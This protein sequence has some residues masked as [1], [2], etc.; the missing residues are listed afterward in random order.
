MCLGVPG[1]IVDT[2]VE[3][4]TPM[5]TVDFGGVTKNVC[6]AYTPDAVAGEY[7]IIHAGFAIS[8]LDEEAA[9]ASLDLFEEIGL[10]E[11]RPLVDEEVES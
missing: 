4:G 3:H 7:V 6:L 11:S 9:M 8:L 1:R 10:V 5:A 2:H